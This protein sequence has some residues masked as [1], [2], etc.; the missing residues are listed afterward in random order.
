MIDT[1]THGVIDYGTG[2]LLI[3]APYLFGFATGGVEQWL[4]QVIGVA[5]IL[6]S[7]LTRY[8][9]SIS[10]M[11]PLKVH[12]G[13]DIAA[14][15]LLAVSPWLFGFADIIWW[16]HLLVG[17]MEIVVAAMTRREPEPEA[18]HRS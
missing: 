16:P 15:I 5:I 11:I 3:V 12:L 9:L 7:L 13:I 14:G 6:M 17:L 8:E 1:R 2:L 10:K 18:R 4:P